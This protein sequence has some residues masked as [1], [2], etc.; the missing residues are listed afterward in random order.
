MHSDES[1]SDLIANLGHQFPAT[2]L[3]AAKGIGRLGMAAREAILPLREAAHDPDPKVREAATQAIGQLGEVAVPILAR[4]LNHSDKYV[5]RNAVWSLGRMSKAARSVLPQICEALKDEDPRT[6]SGAAQALGAMGALASDAIPPLVDAMRGTNIVLCRLAAKAL[7]QIGRPAVGTL[8]QNLRHHD[9]FVRGE[10]AVALGW[11]GP[12][13]AP[14]VMALI[15]VLRST[16]PI[17]RKANAE[18]MMVANGTPPTAVIAQT[19]E[20]PC[21]EDITR[22]ASAQALGRI[23][24]DAHASLSELTRALKDPCELVSKAAELSIRQIRGMV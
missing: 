11:I 21:T 18:K 15:D 9:P 5:R 20:A 22:A 24:P 4:L 19:S 10:A 16:R 12:D 14:A 8:I 23:G 1:L 7:S 17:A 6:A 3:R 2:R 13:A